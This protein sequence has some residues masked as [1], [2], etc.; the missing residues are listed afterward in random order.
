MMRDFQTYGRGRTLEQYR[1]DEAGDYKWLT[2][3]QS[4]YGTPEKTTKAKVARRNNTKTPNRIRLHFAI[5]R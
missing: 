2:K 1:R 4:Q 5:F 3:A